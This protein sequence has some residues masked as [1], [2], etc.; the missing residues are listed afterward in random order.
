MKTDA[1]KRGDLSQPSI[2]QKEKRDKHQLKNL[3]F[4][5][6]PTLSSLSTLSFGLWEYC[7]VNSCVNHSTMIKLDYSSKQT[8]HDVVLEPKGFNMQR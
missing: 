8:Q 3:L 1:A 5:H 6:L 7:S 4:F 2:R